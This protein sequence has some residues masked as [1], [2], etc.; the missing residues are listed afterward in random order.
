MPS[1]LL[2][3]VIQRRFLG[4]V[5]PW[6]GFA[7]ALSTSLTSGALWLL[8]LCPVSL[9]YAAARANVGLL[10]AT[11]LALLTAGIIALA[12]PPVAVVF[13]HAERWRLA[14]ADDRPALAARTGN[15][16]TDPA[17][18]R[19]FGYLMVLAVFAPLWL[20][21]I[22]LFGL[23]IFG[24]VSAPFAVPLSSGPIVIGAFTVDSVGPALWLA[25]LGVLLIPVLLYLTAAFGGVQAAVARVLLCSDPALTEVARSRARLADAFDAERRRIERD[26]HDGAQQRV[27]N[28]TMQ[29]SLAKLDVAADS[30]AFA[31][32]D[33]AHHQAKILMTELRD[34]IRGINPVTL[35]ELGLAAALD[36][37]AA[38][39][40][41][42][43]TV[44]A[45]VGR[46]PAPVETIAYFA[47]AEALTN[48]AKHS[49][50]TQ[51]TV[52]VTEV[53]GTLTVEVR[54]DGGGGADPSRGSGLT[55]L[56]DRIAAAGGR[57]L[58]SSP[59]GGP[60]LVRME[61]PCAS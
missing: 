60:T 1:T 12:G 25:L 56:A 48:V 46:L 34:L 57:L 7:Y 33:S 59:P 24:L 11:L 21:A 50:T 61:L 30:P 43:V 8:L 45:H 32:L 38:D 2:K 13:G 35:K 44:H 51:A 42:T 3:A 26:L 20:G 10:T 55:G 58:L 41:L 40:Q 19:A 37:L 5:W 15:L 16:Y 53:A 17:T 54:D 36:E 29:L 31:A 6:R 9:G 14:L 47:V 52:A 18:W 39:S 49:G 23:L 27:V 4:S 22:G 28:L